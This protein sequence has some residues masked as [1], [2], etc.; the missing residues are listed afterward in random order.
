MTSSP[1]NS[2]IQISGS[3]DPTKPTVLYGAGGLTQMA[4]NIWPKQLP[5]PIAIID[6]NQNVRT[7]TG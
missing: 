1:P 4:L 6:K 7:S 5:K 3:I 2:D